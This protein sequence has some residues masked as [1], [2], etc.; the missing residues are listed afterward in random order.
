[1]TPFALSSTFTVRGSD[2]VAL[3]V[4]LF[5]DECSVTIGV[6]SPRLTL[7]A[8]DAA[9]LLRFLD[10]VKGA[11]EREAFLLRGAEAD[12]R[13]VFSEV[14][15]SGRSGDESPAVS[16]RASPRPLCCH[17]HKATDCCDPDDCGP[18]CENCP[19]CP[20]LVFESA[21]KRNTDAVLDDILGPVTPAELRAAGWGEAK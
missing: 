17:L 5:P 1:M 10:D 2:A 8:P 20:T 7:V 9:A 16:L 3:D 12:A 11:V 4:Q 21:V 14:A 19:T 13:R 18:C 15:A 6:G